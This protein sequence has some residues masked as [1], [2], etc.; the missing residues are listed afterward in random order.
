MKKKN[1]EF[2]FKDISFFCYCSKVVRTCFQISCT[3]HALNLCSCTNLNFQAK[4]L[5][6]LHFFQRS[7]IFSK[8]A[9]LYQLDLICIEKLRI[10]IRK[11]EV[12]TRG[13]VLFLGLFLLPPSRD[14]D[15]SNVRCEYS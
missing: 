8:L 13:S 3:E 6:P 14:V 9:K 15:I 10:A 1:E 2:K 12:A 7:F 11:R 4:L 5:P